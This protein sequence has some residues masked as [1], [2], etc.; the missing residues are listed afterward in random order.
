MKPCLVILLLLAGCSGENGERANRAAPDAE[1]G[2]QAA[3]THLEIL[4]GLYRGVAPGSASRMCIVKSRFGLVIQGKGGRSCAGSGHLSR[5]GDRLRLVMAGDSPCTVEARIAGPD[6]LFSAA[7]P[8]GC[9]YY[10]GKGASLAGAVLV[11]K[12]TGKAEARKARDPVGEP[13]CGPT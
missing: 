13:L 8:K 4:A 6:I 2:L 10:C 12:G 7:V 9:A 1:A 11:Q 5:D 3:P